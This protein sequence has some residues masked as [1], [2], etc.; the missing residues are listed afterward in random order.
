MG[1]AIFSFSFAHVTEV[2]HMQYC[3]T[4]HFESNITFVSENEYMYSKMNRK[5]RTIFQNVL[6]VLCM[7]FTQ[8][9]NPHL[10]LAI[11]RSQLRFPFR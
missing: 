2:R 11:V 10:F 4:E 9:K 6:I 7:F 8:F 3:E 5:S 1:N